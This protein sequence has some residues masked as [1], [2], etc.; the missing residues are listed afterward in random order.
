MLENN[1]ITWFG[2]SAQLAEDQKG[3][4][5]STYLNSESGFNGLTDH[6][7]PSSAALKIENCWRQ[8]HGQTK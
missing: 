5:I 6:F 3:I 4:F 2:I 1:F 8:A 7:S